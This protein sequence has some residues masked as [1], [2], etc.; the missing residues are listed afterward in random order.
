MKPRISPTFMASLMALLSFSSL[1]LHSQEAKPEV[2]LGADEIKLADQQFQLPLPGEI[3]SVLNGVSAA[4]WSKAAEEANAG[5]SSS[6]K[7]DAIESAILLGARTADAFLAIQAKN[8]ALLN[9]ASSDILGA[10]TKLGASK[11]VLASAAAI[12]ENSDAGKWDAIFPLLDGTYSAAY[13]AICEVGD[14]DSA[15]IAAAAGWLRGLE[16]FTAQ[17]T[18]HYTEKSA[19]ALR[20]GEL[21]SDLLAKLSQLP[22]GTKTKPRVKALIDALTTVKPLVSFD[23]QATASEAVVKQLLDAAKSALSH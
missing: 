18:S 2:K 5:S 20:Q 10:A 11:E 9:K 22:A 7:P 8:S 14:M 4:D 19:K 6:D 15:S 1:R 13:A 16:I 23:Q 21:V 3:L 17:L 12:K